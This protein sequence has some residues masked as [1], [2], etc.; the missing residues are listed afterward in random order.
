[1]QDTSQ[2]S[3]R[4]GHTHPNWLPEPDSQA[5]LKPLPSRA[6]RALGATWHIPRHPPYPPGQGAGPQQGAGN[7]NRVGKP[8]AP[9]LPPAPSSLGSSLLEACP[10]SY[11]MLQQHPATIHETPV[12][13]PDVAKFL[14]GPNH[15]QMR[16]PVLG[17]KQ[18]ICLKGQKVLA[19]CTP[20]KCFT[21]P[22]RPQTRHSRAAS[23]IPF[24]SYSSRPCVSTEERCWSLS[25][26]GEE[27]AL[28]LSLIHISEPTR[29]G[30]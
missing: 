3:W 15:A 23:S 2:D 13:T 14:W 26:C 22:G 8:P 1:M 25:L 18:G 4:T 24:S 7:P 16:I 17:L 28:S 20:A 30:I 21:V 6:A 10:A 9:P 5:V 19:L 12:V 11:R 29:R 27:T